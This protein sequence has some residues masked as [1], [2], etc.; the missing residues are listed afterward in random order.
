MDLSTSEQAEI[1]RTF[2]KG[3]RLY[4]LT[5]AD[6]WNDLLDIMEAEVVKAEF[7]L[8]N[9]HDGSSNELLRD[10]RAH[11]RAA[12][13]LFEQLQLRINAEIENSRQTIEFGTSFK[14]TNL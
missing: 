7:R 1:L 9:S 14:N 12:R 3:R 10:L 6:G 4:Q 13:S 5:N 8:M 2:E 11:A